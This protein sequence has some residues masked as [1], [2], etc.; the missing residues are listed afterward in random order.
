MNSEF[1]TIF[2]KREIIKSYILNSKVYSVLFDDKHKHYKKMDSIFN[3]TNTILV[4]VLA[5]INLLLSDLDIKDEFVKTIKNIIPNVLLFLSS[6]MNGIQQYSQFSQLGEK[7]NVISMH[8]RKMIEKMERFLTEHIDV[9]DIDYM[10]RKFK[11]LLKEYDNL[12]IETI[13]I[14]TKDFEKIKNKI[15]NRNI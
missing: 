4:S 12:F 8:Y 9:T 5:T 15:V 1:T 14:E 10:D 13:A 6:L 7:Y 2:N 3:I 11:E